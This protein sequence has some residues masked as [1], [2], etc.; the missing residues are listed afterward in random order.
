LLDL[1]LEAVDQVAVDQFMHL[2]VQVELLLL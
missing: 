1:S 2:M